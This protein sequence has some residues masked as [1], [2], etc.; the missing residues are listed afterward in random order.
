MKLPTIL[1]IDD[2]FARHLDARADLCFLYG[3]KDISHDSK[4]SHTIFNPIAEAVFSSAQNNIDG[5]IT[6]SVDSAIDIVRSGWPLSDG[7][8]WALVLLDLRFVSGNDT[9]GL[10]PSG[11]DGDDT[12]GLNILR[13]MKSE[14][15]DLPVIILSSRERSEVIEDCRRLGAADFIQRHS[16]LEGQSPRDILAS[17]LQEYGLIEDDRGLIAGRSLHLLKTLASARR[18]AS[19]VGNILLL[20]E[21]GTGK[22]L[23]ARYIHDKSPKADGPYRILKAHNTTETLQEDMLFGHEKGAFTGANSARAGLFELADCG[24]LF[25]DEIGDIVE[26]LQNKLL[27]PIETRTIARQGGDREKSVDVQ[28]VLATNKALDEYAATGKF[29]F[30]LLN[31]IQAYEIAIPPL[32]DRK[33]DIPVLAETILE[34]LCKENKARWPR[35]FQSEAMVKLSEHDWLN[36]NIRELRNVLERVVKNNKDSEIVVAR[37]IVFSASIATPQ[38]SSTVP[39][40]TPVLPQEQPSNETWLESLRNIPIIE[41]YDFLNATWPLLHQEL[42]R[43]LVRYLA[44]TLKVNRRKGEINLADAVSCIK[45]ADVD[46]NRAADLIKRLLNFDDGCPD[47]LLEEFPLVRAA[48]DESLNLRPKSPKNGKKGSV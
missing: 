38:T 24:T 3:I 37:D 47:V 13:A 9:G 10:F 42:M 30:D 5:R 18:A 36:G 16:D 39:V 21:S 43:L 25:L 22:E 48:L 6:N 41:D 44:A 35:K 28:L 23:L 20:G 40:E 26:S 11:S 8:R 31:R 19:G 17:K 34:R 29:K 1:I 4:D 15:P 32:R 33:E 14:F 7:R 27:R 12:F 2:Q 45:G 46:K